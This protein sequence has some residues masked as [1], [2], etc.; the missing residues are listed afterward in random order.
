M[1]KEIYLTETPY[2][3]DLNDTRDKILAGTAF[4]ARPESAKPPRRLLDRFLPESYYDDKKIKPGISFY[5]VDLIP[6]RVSWKYKKG[7]ATESTKGRCCRWRCLRL[8]C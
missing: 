6:L 2:C 7:E 1:E 4:P 8:F 3:P 5:K